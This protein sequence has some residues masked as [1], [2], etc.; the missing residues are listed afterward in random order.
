MPPEAPEAAVI[1]AHELRAPL[2]AITAVSGG[3]LE[4]WERLDDGERRSLVG[5]IQREAER[6]ARLVD[7]LLQGDRAAMGA[8]NRQPLDLGVMTAA[9]VRSARRRFP[10]VQLSLELEADLPPVS[11]AADQIEQ[12][13][14]NLVDNACTHGGGGR[15]GISVRRCG[16][17]VAIEVVDDG[18]QLGGN[19]AGHEAGSG[20]G[21]WISHRLVAAHGGQLSARSSVEHGTSFLFTLPLDRPESPAPS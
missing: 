11:A 15:V 21:L 14:V 13:L 4:R 6:G 7:D 5:E 19:P 2:R 18:S 9:V 12:V 20:L 16:P 1:A 8:P 3:L 17:D 10:G